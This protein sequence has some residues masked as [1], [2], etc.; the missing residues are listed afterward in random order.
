MICNNFFLKNIYYVINAIEN[1]NFLKLHIDEQ[2]LLSKFST[3]RKNEFTC[4][5]IIAKDLLELIGIRNFPV[6]RGRLGE[7]IWPEEVAGSISHCDDKCF[8]AI[9]RKKYFTSIGV[10]IDSVEDLPIHLIDSVCT[11]SEKQWI[12]SMQCQGTICPYT[13]MIFSAKESAYKCIFPFVQNYIDFIE[14]EIT[15]GIPDYS[16]RV[17]LVPSM[18]KHLSLPM[19]SNIQGYVFLDKK[20]IL[21]LAAL[22]A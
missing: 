12:R 2:K 9:S 22:A 18:R 3:K 5:R 10:D 14:V 7:P 17:K 1:T 21:T 19:L 16:F 13:K 4:G 15:F 8:V 20:H 6:L 11:A